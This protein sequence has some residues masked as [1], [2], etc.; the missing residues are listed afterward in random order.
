MN[1]MNSTHVL[2]LDIGT[3]SVRGMVFDEKGMPIDGIGKQISYSMD[4]TADGGEFYDVDALCNLVF[5]ILDAVAKQVEQ[6]NTEI[7]AIT[8]CTFC[9]NVLGVDA[10]GNPCTP[11]LNWSDNRPASVMDDLQQKLDPASY[12]A[13]TG[14]PFHASFL[15]AKLTWLAETMPREFKQAKYWMS[16]S[17]YLL[18]VLTGERKCSISMAAF[19]GLLNSPLCEWDEE[20]LSVLPI[21]VEQL[22][23]LD[24]KD[25][26]YEAL[27]PEYQQRWQSLQQAKWFPMLGDGACNNI[28]SGCSSPDR[29]SLMVGTS[30]A[31]RVVWKGEFQKPPEGLWCYRIDKS[32]PVQGGALSNGGNLFAWMQNTLNLPDVEELESVISHL[33]PDSHGLT[34]LPFLHGQR[35][36]RWNANS[37]ALIYGLRAATKPEHILQAGLEAVAMRF[38]L[39]HDLLQPVMADEY[40]LVASGGGLLKSPAW[41]QI[42]ADVLGKNVC[43]S[44][45][46]EASCRG[47]ALCALESLGVLN[48]IADADPCLGETVYPNLAH[49]AV[50]QKAL[51]RHVEIEMAVQHS[52]AFL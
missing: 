49:H 3:S 35:S 28:G 50:Y 17:E 41:I 19:S 8:G 9:H 34:V 43:V 36:P 51:E 44:Q 13:R 24:D 14:C 30:G 25:G 4:K 48:D 33:P 11:I 45:A 5:D 46:Q 39:I 1:S 20:T 37:R 2:S 26:A 27:K 52:A 22:S 16:F 6:Q 10:H 42:M 18:F 15:P 47:A 21:H 29:L 31:M 12:T 40:V 23:L 7:I 38:K 32:R